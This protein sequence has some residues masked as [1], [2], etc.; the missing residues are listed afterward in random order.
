[1]NTKIYRIGRVAVLALIPTLLL[2]SCGKTDNPEA[3]KRDSK[4]NTVLM[5]EPTPDH[6]GSQ[7]GE[8]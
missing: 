7:R 2:S 3:N 8:R 6:E 4:G 5:T 1:M